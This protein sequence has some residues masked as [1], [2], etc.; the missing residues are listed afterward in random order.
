MNIVTVKIIFLHANSTWQPVLC[1]IQDRWHIAH[2]TLCFQFKQINMTRKSCLTLAH[3]YHQQPASL[4][5][6]NSVFMMSPTT[7]STIT[8]RVFQWNPL[9]CFIIIFI[10]TC[11]YDVAESPTASPHGGCQIH[12]GSRNWWFFTHIL[13]CCRMQTMYNRQK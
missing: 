13:L 8:H 12:M 5:P 2:I 3:C 11:I 7:V 9:Q 6:A 1:D 4:L 10:T